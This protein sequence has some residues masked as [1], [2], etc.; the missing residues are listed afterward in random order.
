MSAPAPS[1]YSNAA[2]QTAEKLGLKMGRANLEEFADTLLSLA[3]ADRNI[4]AVLGAG[5][6]LMA[7]T[8]SRSFLR[9]APAFTSWLADYQQT[10]VIDD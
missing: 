5:L 7:A 1:M 6:L 2:R 10:N 3:K 8:G 4:L 9:S